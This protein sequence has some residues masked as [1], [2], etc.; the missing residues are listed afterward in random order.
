MRNDADLLKGPTGGN[1]LRRL[2]N[3]LHSITVNSLVTVL[4][5][6]IE[7][8][9]SSRNLIPSGMEVVWIDPDFCIVKLYTVKSL[10]FAGIL[11]RVCGF[12]NI[13]GR[14]V[15]ENLLNLFIFVSFIFTIIIPL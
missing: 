4:E 13:F 10:I 5:Y 3:M 11:F 7:Y 1:N 12:I 9:A 8:C 6:L 14:I 15:I 2:T